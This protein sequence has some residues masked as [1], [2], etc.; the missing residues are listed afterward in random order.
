[1]LESLPCNDPL[2]EPLPVK[3]QI[4]RIID[5]F[6]VFNCST[7]WFSLFIITILTGAAIGELILTNNIGIF[8]S[9]MYTFIMSQDRNEFRLAIFKFIGMIIG[10]ALVIAI[11]LYLCDRLAILYRKKLG[12]DIHN[13]YMKENTFYELLLYDTDIDNPDSRIA[14][15]VYDYTTN[16]FKII[17]KI[18]QTPAIIIWYSIQSWML[19]NGITVL[20]CFSFALISTIVS[21]LVISKV[22]SKT[23]LYQAKNADFRL[24]HV[25]LK[26]NAETICLS[27]AVETEYRV[28]SDRLASVLDVQKSLANFTFPVNLFSNAFAYYGGAIVYVCIF[29][30]LLNHMQDASSLE[31]SAFASK[32]GFFI[33]ML[34]SGF[35]NVFN[36]MSDI[37]KLCGYATRIIEMKD[38]ITEHKTQV[39]SGRI[40]KFIGMTNVDVKRPTGDLLIQNLSFQVFP[41]DSLFITGPSG[42][43]KSSIF[44]VLGKIWPAFNGEI[45]LP[46]ANPNNLI[47]LTQKS[48]IPPGT[49]DESLTFPIDP[50]NIPK[51]QIL[52]VAT[53]LEIEHLFNRNEKTWQEGLSPGEKQRIALARVFINKPTFALLDEATSAIPHQ[54]E[55]KIYQ[56]LKDLG[57]SIITI[58]HNKNLRNYHKSSLV[59]DGIGGYRLYDNDE[60]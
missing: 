2:L 32:S 49:L 50:Q 24:G 15:D 47:I 4:V 60:Q 20:I 35:T 16:L 8:P 5:A 38:I 12:L 3:Q 54:S 58:A 40:D 41:G 51:Q 57:I 59:I 33:I 23:Y 11:K 42:S 6:R 29:V 25:E 7:T 39:Q 21:R 1:M 17:S 28:L 56:K 10:M 36:M 14:Q 18:I 45:I 52:D 13:F 53:F 43:G 34:I 46:V 27:D 22:V 9:Q 48:Y 19:L 30:Y 55:D 44:R 31:L 37:S 26:E